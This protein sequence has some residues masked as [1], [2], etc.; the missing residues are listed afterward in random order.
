MYNMAEPQ[1]NY[2]EQK[3]PNKRDYILY[4]SIYIKL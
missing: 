3:E 2:A 4:D 1:N